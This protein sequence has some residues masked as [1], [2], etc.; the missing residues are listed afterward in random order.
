M[1]PWLATAVSAIF[2]PG[3]N[4]RPDA[5]RTFNAEKFLWTF[6][7]VTFVFFSLGKSKLP[8]YI[9]PIV[10]LLSIL[11]AN[12]IHN[13]SSLKVNAWLTLSLSII[14]LSVGSVITRFANEKIP[15]D[16]YTNYQP[17]VLA[18]AFMLFLA[19]V[20]LLMGAKNRKYSV[21]IAGMS[22]L[23]SYQLIGWGFQSI[24]ASR[25][26]KDIADAIISNQLSD[27]TVYSVEGYSQSLPFY[28]NKTIVLAGYRGEL[29][30]GIEVE[31]EKWVKDSEQFLE[32][33]SR[34]S[35][36]VAVFNRKRFEKYKAFGIPMRI[37][38]NGPRRVVVAKH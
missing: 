16:L 25:S 7:V 19:G 24:A 17:W 20:S 2:K 37:I 30:M 26:S 3:F 38:Y 11:V 31:P 34:E 14:L 32:L 33:W 18:A 22:A 23:L 21:I 36:A 5:K 27:V 12:K 15:V 9:L 6:C 4:W 29:G 13:Q 28:L 8:A 10:P 35:Q 1:M